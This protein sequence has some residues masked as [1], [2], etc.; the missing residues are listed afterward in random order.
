[1]ASF[2]HGAKRADASVRRRVLE[3]TASVYLPTIDDDFLAGLLD[4][5]KSVRESAARLL[6]YRYP[7]LMLSATNTDALPA[8]ACER[9]RFGEDWGR[10]R[11]S[12]S[13]F[14]QRLPGQSRI[15]LQRF[16]SVPGLLPDLMQALNEAG[17]KSEAERVSRF[18]QED[19]QYG[20][21]SR[22]ILFATTYAC[23][24]RCPY[25]YVKSWEKSF[26]DHMPLENF[27]RALNWCHEQGLNYIIL[28]G[29]E[30]TVHPA[31][32]KLVEEARACGVSLSLTSNGLFGGPV[33]AHIVPDVFPEFICHV[34]QDVIR[35]NKRLAN[36]LS[37]NIS[38]VQAAGVAVRFRYTL[39][40]RSDG[41][42][43]REI[44]ALARAHG[45]QILNYG[46]AFQNI[47][48]NNESYRH[49][50][51]SVR[52]FDS[53]LNQFMDE[54]REFGVALHLS[55][56]F[57]LCHVTRQTLQ[58]MIGEGGLRMACTAARRGYS[59][60]LT[61]NPDLSTLPCNA[62]NIA[63]PKITAFKSVREAGHYHSA[64]LRKLYATPWRPKCKRCVLHFRG[65][66]QGACLAEHV[67]K[68]TKR[69]KKE[70]ARA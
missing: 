20:G 14:V 35:E 66:C 53:L 21:V 17:K 12:L 13:Q 29:G 25:C 55:K 3:M 23:N 10:L 5:S 59:M 52:K 33:L 42:E 39:T 57:P 24:L 8:A 38:A 41:S 63:G 27:R 64:V 7:W 49:E 34:E 15:P 26:P 19:R 56:P 28:G 61:V 51:M 67:A 11:A 70:E 37:R 2:C 16:G 40:S 68:P 69:M 43:R 32:G 54:A 62:L 36:R 47:N 50:R 45:I 18:L 30:P 22:Q 31:F 4:R 46:F 1:M 65:L 44:L 9:Y 60:N 58:R 6:V 48:K